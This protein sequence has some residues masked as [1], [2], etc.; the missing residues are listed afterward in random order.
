MR[1]TGD[2]LDVFPPACWKNVLRSASEGLLQVMWYDALPDPS[3]GDR[4]DQN[5]GM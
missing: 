2:V 1:I 3:G 5:L 4:N